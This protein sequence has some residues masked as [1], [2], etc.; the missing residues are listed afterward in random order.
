MTIERQLATGP[1]TAGA[2]VPSRPITP[3]AAVE[4]T[5]LERRVLA[6]E[7]ILQMLI[8]HLSEVTP[9]ILT[10]LEVVFGHPTGNLRREHDFV[11]TDAYAGQFVRE[12]ERLARSFAGTPPA[13]QPP[14]PPPRPPP[15]CKTLVL[16]H[17]DT[18][19]DKVKAGLHWFCKMSRQ[20]LPLL[21]TLQ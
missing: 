17:P 10:R 2:G 18:P 9:Q 21:F 20:M 5:D 8:A 12:V 15:V 13:S 19:F 7:R 14:P 6:H 16:R 11:D 1:P 4:D 3:L